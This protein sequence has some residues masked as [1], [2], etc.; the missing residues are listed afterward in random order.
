[1]AASRRDLRCEPAS[2][3]EASFTVA[4]HHNKVEL[5]IHDKPVASCD[6]NGPEFYNALFRD[7]KARVEKGE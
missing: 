3:G 1:M 2:K 5:I 6:V 4:V 7:V